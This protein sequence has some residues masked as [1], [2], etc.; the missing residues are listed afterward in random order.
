MGD[1]FEVSK[2]VISSHGKNKSNAAVKDSLQDL[3]LSNSYG[4]AMEA[5]SSLITLQKRGTPSSI[6]GKY[7]KL[8]RMQMYLKVDVSIIEF[9]LGGRKDSTNVI[10]EP[11]VCGITP[12]GMDHTEMQIYVKDY[13]LDWG[14]IA[15]IRGCLVTILIDSSSTHNFISKIVAQK[16]GATLDS[17]SALQVVVANG[18]KIPS[19]GT[20]KETIQ[21]S[22]EHFPIELYVIPL[23]GFDV[24]LG[25]NQEGNIPEAFLRGLATAHLSW[26]AQVVYDS[27][28]NC[29]SSS[30]LLE[31][32]SG[33]D[34]LL[35]WS[36]QSRKHGG[37]YFS[38]AIFVPCIS[39][40]NKVTSGT[41][42]IP[43]GISSQDLSWQFSLQRLWEKII[44]GIDGDVVLDKSSKLDSAETLPP[45]EFLYEDASGC[46]PADGI[47]ACNSVISSLPLTLNWLR[48]CIRENP[49]LRI[50]VRLPA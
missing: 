44:H 6:G 23:D 15:N 24:V 12:L 42:A 33:F 36:S 2:D 29:H 38:K 31:N 41:S 46:S 47:L 32:S 37:I 48:D 40:Y 21:V 5:L 9:G 22:G 43:S 50:Q 20:C 45:R 10:K 34:F 39:T 3:P 18:E 1:R 49:T 30:A 8:D 19:M 14:L 11:V 35:G 17:Q 27:S 4:T 7:G 13:F 28:S 26:R 16:L 25:D